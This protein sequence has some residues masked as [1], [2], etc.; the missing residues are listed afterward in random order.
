MQSDRFQ[1]FMT[2]RFQLL[3]PQLALRASAP[4]REERFKQKSTNSAQ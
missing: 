2:F 1:V 3:L 4:R